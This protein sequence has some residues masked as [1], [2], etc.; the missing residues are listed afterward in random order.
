[1]STCDMQL[2]PARMCLVQGLHVQP[3]MSVVNFFHSH[4]QCHLAGMLLRCRALAQASASSLC[5]IRLLSAWKDCAHSAGVSQRPKIQ[6]SRGRTQSNL[7]SVPASERTGN[8]F[9]IQNSVPSARTVLGIGT[10]M[11]I[12]VAF[13][14][15]ARPR[16]HPGKWRMYLIMILLLVHAAIAGLPKP[17]KVQ[18]KKKRVRMVTSIELN[19]W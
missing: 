9:L 3:L 13:S 10:V 5:C 14:M 8:S 16:L 17:T 4:C 2:L 1:M 7:R 18:F 15:A 11:W 12:A 6:E 19:G